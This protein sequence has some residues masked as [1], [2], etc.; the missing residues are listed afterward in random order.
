M[1]ERGWEAAGRREKQSVCSVFW[2]GGLCYLIAKYAVELMPV[3][4]IMP[5]W[6]LIP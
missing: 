2:R 5:A 1:S 4:A 3:F 6:T